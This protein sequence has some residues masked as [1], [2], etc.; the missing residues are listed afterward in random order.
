MSFHTKDGGS[1][2]Q[3][4]QKVFS[5]HLHNQWEKPYPKAGWV[6]RLLLSRYQKQLETL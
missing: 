3:V 2:D 6:E 4:L 1:L 5:V